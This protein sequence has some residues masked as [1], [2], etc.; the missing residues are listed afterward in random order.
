ME[1]DNSCQEEKSWKNNSVQLL[2]PCLWRLPVGTYLTWQLAVVGLT[3]RRQTAGPGE[4]TFK[5]WTEAWQLFI[6]GI[7]CYRPFVRY[8]LLC[9]VSHKKSSV[10]HFKKVGN[11]ISLKTS[12]SK[13]KRKDV[14][15]LQMDHAV[16]GGC[17]EILRCVRGSSAGSKCWRCVQ[18][19]QT[20]GLPAGL[21]QLKSSWNRRVDEKRM[22]GKQPK[23]KW[24]ESGMPKLVPRYWS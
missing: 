14:T 12:R 8:L 11:W 9:E 4:V 16:V 23:W 24:K 20:I 3:G 17:H 19:S 15:K 2:P 13:V 10:C 18:T 5:D 21:R 1:F 22:I 7:K 6:A